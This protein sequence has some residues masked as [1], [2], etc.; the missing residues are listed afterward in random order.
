ML[1]AVVSG[2]TMCATRD[3]HHGAEGRGGEG[4]AKG[5]SCEEGGE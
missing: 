2:G 1:A 4:R 5:A 3:V